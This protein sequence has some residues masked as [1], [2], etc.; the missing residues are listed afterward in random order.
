MNKFKK[1]TSTVKG[2]NS[3]KLAKSEKNDCFVRALA[4]ATDSD[5]D[6]AHKYVKKTFKRKKG[7][8]VQFLEGHGI[9]HY[10]IPNREYV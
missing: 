6:L 7:K 10:K 1:S 8:G 4:A 3:S 9:W 5:Y 2:Y